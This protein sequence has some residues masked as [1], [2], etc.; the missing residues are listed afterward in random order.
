MSSIPSF[1]W[2]DQTKGFP[3]SSLNIGCFS[4]SSVW[5]LLWIT[6]IIP[7]FWWHEQT[8]GFPCSRL[9]NGIFAHLTVQ[10]FLWT[11]A[12]IPS[13][14][15]LEQTKGFPH[16]RLNAG[17]FLKLSFGISCCGNDMINRPCGNDMIN[18]PGLFKKF[19][20]FK[21]IEKNFGGNRNK[22]VSL[23]FQ[24]TNSRCNDFGRFLTVWTGNEYERFFF[25]CFLI[26]FK[27]SWITILSSDLDTS[28]KSK[29]VI[30][31]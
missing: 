13:S 12:L 4:H 18:R 20:I 15:W 16:S 24:S 31:C 9:N 30:W 10:H 17:C 22:N 29:T 2:L 7:S 6:S 25:Y 1:W 8:Q 3:R 5:H 28:W 26:N 23:T 27:K 14:R 11:T 21:I 19:R